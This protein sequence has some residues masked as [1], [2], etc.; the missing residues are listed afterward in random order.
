MRS[1]TEHELAIT[2]DGGEPCPSKL[3]KLWREGAHV[4]LQLSVGGRRFGAH[5]IVV[6]AGSLYIRPFLMGSGAILG[7]QLFMGGF[8][9]KSGDDCRFTGLFM[10][11]F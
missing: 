5:K 1:A 8:G 2:L 7:L 11:L 10:M 3:V 4:D 6:S 9:S